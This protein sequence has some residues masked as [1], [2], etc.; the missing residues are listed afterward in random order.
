[1]NNPHEY[2]LDKVFYRKTLED[3]AFYRKIFQATAVEVKENR[4]S[5]SLTSTSVQ[6]GR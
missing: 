3:N 4:T 6:I 5:E 2:Y 1:M